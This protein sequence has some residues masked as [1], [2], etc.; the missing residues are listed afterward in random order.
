MK[1]YKIARIIE[2]AAIIV[3]AAVLVI[4]MNLPPEQTG[5]NTA[6]RVAA[7]VIAMAGIFLSRKYSVCPHCG[8]TIN[9]L[10]RYCSACGERL[11]K[12]VKKPQEP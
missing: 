11:N 6:C 5:W 9:V 2:L 8:K 3:A 1:P 10:S 12:E 4:G 7:I